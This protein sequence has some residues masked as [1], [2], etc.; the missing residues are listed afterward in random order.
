MQ[1]KLVQNNKLKWTGIMQYKTQSTLP[2]A[3]LLGIS[4]CSCWSF[5]SIP[6]SYPPWFSWFLAIM[7]QTKECNRNHKFK[8]NTD[9]NS[10]GGVTYVLNHTPGCFSPQHLLLVLLVFLFHPTALPEPVTYPRR[11]KNYNNKSN[12]KACMFGLAQKLIKKCHNRLGS[13]LYSRSRVIPLSYP[14]WFSWFF[15]H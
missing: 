10:E 6:W 3:S 9:K 15:S 4:C 8:C 13:T 7:Q 1:K 11:R 14:P 12:A 5:F 2:G